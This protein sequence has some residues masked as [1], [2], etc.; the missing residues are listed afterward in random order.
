MKSL[1][2]GGLIVFTFLLIPNAELFAQAGLV[3]CSGVPGDECQSCRL[4]Q[5]VNNIVNFFVAIVSVIAGIVIVVSGFRLVMSGGNVTEYKKARQMLSNA[6]IGLIIL[7]AGWLIVDT[8]VRLLFNTGG[9]GPW[10]QIQCV[11]QPQSRAF[12]T[13]GGGVSIDPSS[14]GAPTGN[15]SCSVISSG[16]CSANSLQSTFGDATL[17]SQASQVCN[18]ESAGNVQSE[19]LTDRISTGEAFSFGL[20]QINISVHELRGCGPGGGTLN[21][22]EAFSGRNYNATIVNQSLYQQCAAAAKTPSCNLANAR[23]IYDGRANRQ[24][25][26]PWA[27]WS[28]ARVCGLAT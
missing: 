10:N 2:I 21:C 9:F 18:G 8:V 1:L 14:S 27:D 13:V 26:N 20:F 19:S 6:I 11:D 5:L 7:L 25:S 15:G 17:A 12:N 28:A 22:P 4:V 23:R 24:P 3:P 16:P